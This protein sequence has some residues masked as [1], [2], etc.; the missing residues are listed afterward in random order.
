MQQGTVKW[1]DNLKGF[2]YIL[3]DRGG[4]DLF[5]HYTQIEGRG[6]RSLTEGQRVQ[7]TI[8]TSRKGIVARDVKKVE[9]Q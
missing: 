6:W 3:P 7:F 1:F 4:P 9:N 2:G 5:V 8:G